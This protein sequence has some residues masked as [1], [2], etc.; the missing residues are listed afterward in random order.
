MGTS[1]EKGVIR[2]FCH[3]GNIT[4][5]SDLHEYTN[6]HGIA[7]CTPRPNG[8]NLMEP[9]SCMLSVTECHCVAHDCMCMYISWCRREESSL[10]MLGEGLAD[11]WSSVWSPCPSFGGSG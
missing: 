5:Y 3:R 4:E 9:L 10:L 1:H 6:L 2:R 7:H 8:S 11:P